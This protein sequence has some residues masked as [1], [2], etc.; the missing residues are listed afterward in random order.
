MTSVIFV[1]GFRILLRK[2]KKKEK[3]GG[4]RKKL[5]SDCQ[6]ELNTAG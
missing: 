3:M 5:I 1:F 2:K 4:G 6:A